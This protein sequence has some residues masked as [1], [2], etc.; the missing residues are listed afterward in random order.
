MTLGL[1]IRLGH[2]DCGSR[3]FHL[4]NQWRIRMQ[5][6]SH[7]GGVLVALCLVVNSQLFSG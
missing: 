2:E 4:R 7:T 3:T 6:A 5:F 1:W